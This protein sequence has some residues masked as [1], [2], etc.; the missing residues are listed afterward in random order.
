MTSH[1]QRTQRINRN[2]YN[3]N[4]HNNPSK[5][6]GGSPTQSPHQISSHP[7]RTIVKGLLDHKK[8]FKQVYGVKKIDKKN[9]KNVASN[10]SSTATTNLPTRRKGLRNANLNLHLNTI[11][12]STSPKKGPISVDSY[13]PPPRTKSAT[14]SSP[15]SSPSSQSSNTKK[16]MSHRIKGILKKS[17]SF[18]NNMSSSSWLMYKLKQKLSPRQTH[19]NSNHNHPFSTRI[20]SNSIIS[21]IKTTSPKRQYRRTN[22]D[23]LAELIEARKIQVSKVRFDLSK[24]Q[25]FTPL[26]NNNKYTSSSDSGFWSTTSSSSSLHS[27]S[28]IS[29]ASS[30]SQSSSSSSSSS[31][32]VSSSTSA[33]NT[34]DG[35]SITSY[36]ESTASPSYQNSDDSPTT[37]KGFIR[38][39]LFHNTTNSN[40]NNK[41]SAPTSTVISSILTSKESLLDSNSD[42]SPNNTT[43]DSNDDE[44]DDISNFEIDPSVQEEIINIVHKGKKAQYT[45]FQYNKASKHYLNAISKL[46][47]NAYP[48]NHKLRQITMT[49]L[50]DTHHAMRSLEHSSDIVKMGLK[51][52]EKGEFIKALKMYTIAFRIRRDAMGKNHPSLPILLNM[53]GSVQM[54]RGELEE[55]MQIFELAL[56]GRLKNDNMRV[57]GKTNVSSSTKAVSMR[58]MGQ[59]HELLGQIDNALDMYHDSLECVLN[60]MKSK[61]DTKKHVKRDEN[62]QDQSNND[63]SNDDDANVDDSNDGDDTQ[64]HNSIKM[65]EGDD[66]KDC[67]HRDNI[68]VTQTSPSSSSLLP[69]LPQSEEME[70]F[71]ENQSYARG[72]TRNPSNLGAFYNSFFADSQLITSKNVTVQ[73]AMTLHNI[74][75]IHRKSK[76]YKMAISAYE[77]ALR[78]METAIGKNHPNI[79]AILGNIGNVHKDMKNFDLAY[80]LYQDVLEI[81]S[82]NLGFAHPEVIVTMHNIAMIQKCRGNF[83]DSKRLYREAL[84]IQNRL[85]EKTMKWYNATAVSYSCLGDVEEKD[86]NYKA[87]ID[88]YKEALKIRSQHVDKFN[89]DLGKLLHKIGVL[90]A[91]HGSLRDATIYFAKALKL[92]EFNNIKDSRLTTVLRD[93]ADVL[94]KIAFNSSTI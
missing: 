84:S 11:I 80:N 60:S 79:A 59:I 91:N 32:V 83:K 1:Q 7:K 88:A 25:I 29:T 33:T 73:V 50:N 82:T 4:K 47:Q 85:K 46:D 76:N 75:N 21:T 94:G 81:E 52:E 89:P 54:K 61:S 53:L 63:K 92:Y 23:P 3:L 40:D 74:A 86:G 78:G 12:K 8:K 48:T 68:V 5:A 14:S 22:S 41:D 66:S 35:D 70:I 2:F 51:H 77:S 30:Y 24:N 18:S 20:R 19:N 67:N 87:A 38:R 15:S 37:S 45:T 64:I 58:E 65:T 16:T 39:I 49:L 10:H 71:L 36:S 44:E 31:S 26:K 43:L 42:E 13:I 27:S 62:K 17:S 34:S 55:A 90:N 6:G 57:V 28:T 69:T 72:N 56:Y 9:A 93:Q